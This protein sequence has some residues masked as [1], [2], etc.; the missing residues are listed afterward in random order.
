MASS[1]TYI[2]ETKI[3]N[4]FGSIFLLFFYG[5]LRNEN[6]WSG[7]EI[8]FKCLPN[9]SFHLAKENI[10]DGYLK[11]YYHHIKNSNPTS[12]WW[13]GE[14]EMVK[15]PLTE[16]SIVEKMPV[17]FEFSIYLAT[18]QQKKNNKIWLKLLW[19]I[20]ILMESLHTHTHTHCV[21]CKGNLSW[22]FLNNIFGKSS[23]SFTR[24]TTF[25]HCHFALIKQT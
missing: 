23:L 22:H 8:L 11:E 19:K 4:C 5:S 17:C 18:K 21:Q 12:L 1:Y 10:Y 16:R 13:E 20:Q 7:K 9:V 2:R 6:I 3:Y 24:R 25:N 14:K 15:N